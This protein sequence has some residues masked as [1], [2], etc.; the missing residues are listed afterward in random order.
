[1]S[2]HVTSPVLSPR[3]AYETI[4]V[5]RGCISLGLDK[6]GITLCASCISVCYR[7]RC[8]EGC[9]HIV[10]F[11][12]V[13]YGTMGRYMCERIGMDRSDYGGWEKGGDRGCEVAR[14]EK[15]TGIGH[16]LEVGTRLQGS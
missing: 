3:T 10:Y 11:V 9:Y 13:L 14:W 4:L 1:M 5:V 2:C 6:R 16:F 12:H 7:D 15:G 8:V